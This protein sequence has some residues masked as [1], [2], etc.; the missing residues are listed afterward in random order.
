MAENREQII[1]TEYSEIMQKSY[2]D[3]A[4]SVIIARALPD[5]RDG[6][7][8]VQRRT[9]YDMHE[10]GI[11]YDRPYRKCA[12]IVGDTMGKYHP[13]GDSSIYGALVVMAQDFK[14]GM[15]LVDGHGNFGSIE[16]DGAAAMRYTEAR[17]QKITQQAYLADLDKDVVDF[18]PN[19]DATEKEPSVLP[20]KVPNILINVAEGI[21]VGMA[22]S[23]PPHN[24]GEVI[25]GVIAYMK[26]PDINTEQMMQYIPGPD[27]P[28]G[29]V[30]ANKDEL[31]AIY[32]TGVGKIKIRGK[33]EVE[34]V[35]GGKERLVIT[36]IPYTM[37][38]ANI[39]KFLNDIATLVETKKTTDIVD[40]TLHF[41]CRFFRIN[42]SRIIYHDPGL[43]CQFKIAFVAIPF[44]NG[45]QDFW[46]WIWIAH[47]FEQFRILVRVAFD[48]YRHIFLCCILRVI[49]I[50]RF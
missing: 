21:S 31:T 47:F 14:Y 4:M 3:Y 11:R 45:R 7:K 20:V 27:F 49:F 22:T 19:F 18:I 6:L 38:G 1:R 5:V 48:S 15:P 39:G 41:F 8:P 17:L 13:H 35:K 46:H 33:V 12:R 43:L 42:P 37:I 10:L 29:G 24:L 23:I 2:I 36:E 30:I 28:T 50:G 34:Q 32:S 40:I 25:D 44:L 26:N 16:G 9:L